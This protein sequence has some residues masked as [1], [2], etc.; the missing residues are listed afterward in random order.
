[1][2]RPEVTGRKSAQSPKSKPIKPVV[3]GQLLYSRRQTGQLLGNVSVATVKR[4]EQR[5]LLR[6]IQLLEGGQVFHNAREVRALVE[7]GG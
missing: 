4:M 5:G 2:S 1:M 7:G 6:P 3:D